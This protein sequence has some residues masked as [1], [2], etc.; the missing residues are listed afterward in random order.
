MR[1]L[2]YRCFDKVQSCLYLGA[3]E[4]KYSALKKGLQVM[5]IKNGKCSQHVSN[6]KPTPLRCVS[7]A[8]DIDNQQLI[9]FKIMDLL[10]IKINN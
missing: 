8:S 10:V 7:N 6:I 2:E 1:Q 4:W 5:N 3:Q 9:I